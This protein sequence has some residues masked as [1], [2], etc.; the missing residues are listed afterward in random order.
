MKHITNKIVEFFVGTKEYQERY[1]K[2]WKEY[3]GYN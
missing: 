2:A 3:N 1:E